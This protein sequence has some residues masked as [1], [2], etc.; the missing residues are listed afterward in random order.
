MGPGILVF[1]VKVHYEFRTS[2]VPVAQFDTLEQAQ[3]WARSKD[4][5][6]ISTLKLVKVTTT[7]KMEAA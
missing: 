6:Y 4:Y 1:M 7:V 3:K 5:A 2:K